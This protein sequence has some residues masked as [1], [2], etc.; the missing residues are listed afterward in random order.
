[1]L[2]TENARIIRREKIK[3]RY[4]Q[5]KLTDEREYPTYW[6]KKPS[7]GVLYIP[8]ACNAHDWVIFYKPIHLFK[9]RI[10]RSF[11]E[12]LLR[13]L[14]PYAER[15]EIFEL[16]LQK[17]TRRSW[18]LPKRRPFFGRHHS[19][20]VLLKEAVLLRGAPKDVREAFRR[21]RVSSGEAAA[22]TRRYGKRTP[23]IYRRKTPKACKIWGWQL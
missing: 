20:T 12:K 23:A 1:M 2:R 10:I 7:P 8:A 16:L 19:P 21:M 3:R 4:T 22:L 5:S 15:H 13:K 17:R 14:I 6:R 9:G 18:W 11:P